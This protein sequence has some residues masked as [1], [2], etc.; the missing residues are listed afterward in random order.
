MPNSLE[1]KIA[2]VT[3]VRPRKGRSGNLPSPRPVQTAAPRERWY[4]FG[5]NELE[6][7]FSSVAPRLGAREINRVEDDARAESRASPE[8]AV[9]EAS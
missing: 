9:R 6:C 2:V 1:G 5:S 3:G 4:P 8:Q 7:W